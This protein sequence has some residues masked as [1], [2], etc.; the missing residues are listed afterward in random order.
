MSESRRE[1]LKNIAMAVTV[2]AGVPADA[3]Q[4]VHI[5]A[6]EAKAA[7][8]GKYT[9]KALNAHE[10]ATVRRLTELIIPADDVSG[11]A[12]EAGA[13]EFIDLIAANNEALRTEVVG[14]LAWLDRAMEKRASG[15]SFVEAAVGDQT[16]MLD[17]I[18]FRKN[19]TH[20]TSHGI[21]FF[22][23]MR[24][25][26]ADAFYT[27]P[28][29]VKDVGYMGNKGMTKFEVP[30]SAIKYAVNRSPFKG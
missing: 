20:E 23:W 18:A 6:G 10:Y 3:A 17:I 4:H 25:L 14:G 21:A 15:K 13:P 8:G 9:P 11:S 7:A 2:A 16:A 12:V 22:D 30:L 19:E 29:G 5:A 28:I 27:S 26:T 1:V 24:R